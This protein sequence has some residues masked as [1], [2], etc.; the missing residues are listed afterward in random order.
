LFGNFILL[1]KS[2]FQQC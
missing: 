2:N 1:H